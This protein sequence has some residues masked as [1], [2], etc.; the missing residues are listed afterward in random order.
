M[1][2]AEATHVSLVPRGANM[3][4]F[5]IVKTDGQEGTNML[6]FRSVFK[7][8]E[9]KPTVLAVVVPSET[10]AGTARI[11]AAGFSTE[12][13]QEVDGAVAYLQQ[14]DVELGQ[15]DQVIVKF[16]EG[17]SAVVRLKRFEPF[18]D[19]T[20]FDENLQKNGF[21]PGFDMALT[22]LRDTV[23][24]ALFEADDAAA[25][26]ST[27]DMAVKQFRGHIADMTSALP[28]TAFKLDPSVALAD[29]DE[30]RR[31]IS[32]KGVI[33]FNVR[34]DTGPETSVGAPSIT[35][36]DESQTEGGEEVAVAPAV[37]GSSSSLRKEDETAEDTSEATEVAAKDEGQ[38][39]EGVEGKSPEAT[40]SDTSEIQKQISD[41]LAAGLATISTTLKD[42]VEGINTQVAA[43]SERVEKA[44]ENVNG[45]A[46][47]S[48]QDDPEAVARKSN[49]A[50]I[51]PEF[52][53]TGWDR[54]RAE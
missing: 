40:E 12:F 11:E 9:P 32:Q 37:S 28:E 2:D 4:P 20:S 52:L 27:I 21:L 24:N 5:R 16:D 30:A 26:G 25:A 18:G 46:A 13:K 54:L 22:V 7:I 42:A 14:E 6:N 31:E 48:P 35:T 36:V 44:E 38:D 29:T 33:Q 43:L 34:V 45:T 1:H 17:L 49:G 47:A 3:I 50:Y 23:F 8:E 41:A 10:D 19:S 51:E 15:A 39:G 53:D